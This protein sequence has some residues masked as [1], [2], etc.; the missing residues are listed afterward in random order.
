MLKKLTLVLLFNLCFIANAQEVSLYQQFLGKYDF[1]MIGNTMNFEPNGSGGLCE[2]NTTSSAQ[3]SLLP[4]QEIEAAYLY[5]GG[6]NDVLFDFDIKLNNVPIVPDRIFQTDIATRPV[7]GGFKDVT[8]QVKANGNGIYTVSD[9]DLNDAIQGYCANGTNF[10][11]WSILIIYSDPG[12]GSNLVNIYDGFSRVDSGNNYMEFQLNNLNVL[13]LVGNRIGFL[14]W[15]GDENIANQE[16]LKI[17]GNIVSN[18]PLNP[19]NNVFNGTN[20]FTNSNQLYNMDL[21]FFDISAFTNIGDNTMTVSIE[22]HQDAVILNNL[23]LVLNTEVPDA[24][25]ETQAEYGG[26][27]NYEVN[28]DYKVRNTIATDILPAGTPIA[29]YADETLV[30][31][32]ATVNDIPIGG[33]EDGHIQIIIPQGL[34]NPFTL[35]AVIDDD[36]EGN[37]TVVEFNEDNNTDEIQIKLGITPTVNEFDILQKCDPNNDGFEVFDLTITGAQM[38]GAQTGVLIRYYV[39][40]N[41]ALSGNNNN[42]NNPA[43]Y[44]N[45]SSPQTL[46]IRMQDD[47]GCSV[48]TPFQIEIVPPE[49]MSYELPDIVKCSPNQTASGH[50]TDLTENQDAILNGNNSADYTIS[51]HLSEIA[52]RNGSN[53]IPNP[54]DFVNTTSPQIIW[55]RML[56]N[57]GN[58]VLYGSFSLIYNLPPVAHNIQFQKCNISGPATFDLNELNPL[59]VNS[60]T[61]LDF[62]YYPTQADAENQTNSLPFSFT[63]PG[64]LYTVYVRITDANSCTTIVNAEL[65]TVI[66]NAE[67]QNTYY[68]CDDPWEESDGFTV[69]DL[70]SVNNQILN[71]LNLTVANISF[72][73]NAEDALAGVNAIQNPTTYT[74]TANPQKIYARA[75]GLDE[76][77]GGTAEFFIETLPVPVFELPETLIFCSYDAVKSYTFHSPHYSYQWTDANGNVISNQNRVEFSE[78]GEYT[79]EVKNSQNG[80]GGKRSLSVIIDTPPVIVDIKVEDQTVTVSATGGS[81]PY[82]Y[83]LNNGLSWGNDYIFYNMMGGLYDLLVRSKYG[84]VSSSKFFGVLSA[85]NFISPNGDGK[86]D[87]WMVRGLEAFPKAHIQI[88]DRYGKIFIDR[89]LNPD[90]RWDGTY[91]GRP[92]VSG[93]YWYIIK[94]ED[95]RKL[96]GHISVRNY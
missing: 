48:V 11:G 53:A 84:C 32:T 89:P 43:A 14:A 1:T 51:Y 41:D 28:V 17:N 33:S 96:S 42:L 26:C 73:L 78:E 66:N 71:S 49:A 95:G 8:A 52:A 22:S 61:N 72:Y 12:L 86:N 47:Y 69:F 4:S 79:L 39:N 77:C 5:W 21:D 45:L 57:E 58:C 27:D 38:L 44:T 24:T 82:Q 13:N 60:A 59:F 10:G 40:E 70:T 46:Y 74:N 63:P 29:F 83:S 87:Y 80:C 35:I 67:L 9:F 23:V 81:V 19:A 34:A 15:E 20:S 62:V 93:D 36:G 85:P 37:S 76:N 68:E 50:H 94:F 7:S 54:E 30:A 92:V 91:M 75:E 56:R 65:E 90:F 2:I 3:L 16:L 88:F 64:L 55:V 31:T 6:S 25:I 18:P